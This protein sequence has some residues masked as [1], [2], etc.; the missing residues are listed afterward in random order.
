MNNRTAYI[1]RSRK[2][3]RLQKRALA[4]ALL[5][6]AACTGLLL[7]G[8]HSVLQGG[9]KDGMTRATAAVTTA[10][11]AAGAA[12]AAEAAPAGP[13]RVYPYSIV[14]GGV[15]GRAELAHIIQ[16]DKVVAAHYASFEVAKAHSITVAK[17]RAVHVSY[18]KGDQV[19]WTAKK[20]M[21]AEGETLLSDGKSEI[22][23]RCGNRISEVAM[24]PVEAAAPSEDDLDAAVEDD[25][26]GGALQVAAPF[27]VD[28]A[29]RGSHQL[30]TYPNG[31]GLLAVSGGERWGGSRSALGSAA[32]PGGYAGA[33]YGTPTALT[34]G[35]SA[36]T[37]TG[38]TPS[39]NGGATTG[40][41]GNG[42]TP[43]SATTPVA[44]TA[45]TETASGAGSTSETPH[46]GTSAATP[47]QT[48][49]TG[50]STS[51]TPRGG[52]VAGTTPSSTDG[53]NVA[54]TM[55]SSTDGGS[56]GLPLA[57]GDSGAP[58]GGSPLDTVGLPTGLTDTVQ[59]QPE[60]DIKPP[61]I[62][63]T[64]LWPEELP[65]V[66]V[67]TADTTAEAPEPDSLWLSGAGIAA[68]LLL[69]R[70]RQRRA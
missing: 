57:D 1:R 5:G 27:G 63:D 67:Q 12:G 58:G 13:R 4:V 15:A 40:S 60:P 14:A 51:E 39:G 8:G 48:A 45:P 47:T 44:A 46:A 18:R 29:G 20:V 22:R 50:G 62:P 2:G 19:Y 38:G 37:G 31:A 59:P 65:T 52:S 41:G 21:L 30:L 28:G 66:P 56:S 35:S 10:V 70:R 55:P 3:L 16:T 25:G 6:V 34:G 54:G 17:P 33:Y 64:L 68:L 43:V 26:Q 9:G 23:G 32:A 24:L 49:S 42:T 11:A 7:Q 69:R 61:T 36:Q 53:G